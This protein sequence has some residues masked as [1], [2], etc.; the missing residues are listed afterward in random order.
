MCLVSPDVVVIHDAVRPL[1][2]EDTVKQVAVAAWEY[3]VSVWGSVG[4]RVS[5]WSSA[6]IRVSVWGSARIRGECL[7]QC[8]NTG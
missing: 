6:R 7:G 4:I 1:V 3:G 2:D 8:G 5:V